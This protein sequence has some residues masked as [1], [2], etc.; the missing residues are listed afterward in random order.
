MAELSK[1]DPLQRFT[2]MA[3][4]YAR[5][6]PSYPAAAL[7]Y[8][9]EQCGLGPGK[10]LVDVGCGTG[11]ATRQFAARG[12][13][14][15]GIEPNDDMRRQ[16]EAEPQFRSTIDYRA[17][18]AESTG[19]PDAS[20]DAVLAAQAFH[21]FDAQVALCE[22]KRILKP[23]GW[24]VILR[25][26]RNENDTATAAYGKIIGGTKE[27][28]GIEGPRRKAAIPLQQ[29]ALFGRKQERHFE[30]AQLV[31]EDGLLG[32]AFSASYAP[33]EAAAAQQFATDLRQVFA[34]F[35]KDG[36]FRISY[37]TSV[38][39]AQLVPDSDA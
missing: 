19:L 32:R 28:V 22:F 14:V 18:R 34:R 39:V 7:D 24:V 6:R 5:C 4:I 15:L 17:G 20:A 23:G 3:G 10:V 11:I 35:Q 29:T 26:E 30:H 38:D 27:A 2:G 37:V 16:A 31:D 9:L 8:I 25:N 12:V 36:R 33:K 21:W 1:N 13:R